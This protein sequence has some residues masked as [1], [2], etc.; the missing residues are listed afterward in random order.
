[1][2]CKYF[3]WLIF[4]GNWTSFWTP[5]I[6]PVN[7][8]KTEV[9]I[10]VC[11]F[12]VLKNT[13]DKLKLR[14]KLLSKTT[15]NLTFIGIIYKKIFQHL[16]PITCLCNDK[17]A[18]CAPCT[19]YFDPILKMV[20]MKMQVFLLQGG[21]VTLIYRAKTNTNRHFTNSLRARVWCPWRMPN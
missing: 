9:I 18:L 6:I 2:D 1:M 11:H 16:F 12:L 20:H 13:A 7:S 14:S 10:F 8:M 4:S 21:S 19:V 5:V 17:P 15:I 3:R